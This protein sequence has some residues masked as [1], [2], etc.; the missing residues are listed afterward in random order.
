MNTKK[1][2]IIPEKI[3]KYITVLA[4][5]NTSSVSLRTTVPLHIINQFGLKVGDK[6]EW[7]LVSKNGE[8]VVEVTPRVEGP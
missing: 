6:L 5:A 3:Q 4:K 8:L 2:Q 1:T 7:A